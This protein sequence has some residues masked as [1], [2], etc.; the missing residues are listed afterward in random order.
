MLMGMQAMI[1]LRITDCCY[2]TDSLQV[3]TLRTTTRAPISVECQA[4]AEVIQIWIFY[5]ITRVSSVLN[6]SREVYQLAHNLAHLVKTR[7]IQNVPSLC[8]L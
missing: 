2:F 1:S 8:F 3:S 5:S 6:T 7:L 4:H